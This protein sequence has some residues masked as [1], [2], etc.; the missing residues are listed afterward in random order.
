M[1]YINSSIAISEEEFQC[2]AMRAQGAGGQHVNKTSSAIHLRFN[3][4]QSSLPEDVK[5]RLIS[6]R[7]HRITQ[8]GEILIKSQEYRSQDMNR[9]AAQERLVALI[10]QATIVQKPRKATKPSRN[11]VKRRLDKKTKHSQQKQLRK[12]LKY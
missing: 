1:L 6:L 8:E 10:Q 2:S 7:D 3:I 11:S 12:S 4:R 5:S 9:Q